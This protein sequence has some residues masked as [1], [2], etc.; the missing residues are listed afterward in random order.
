VGKFPRHIT[1]GNGDG[2]FVEA[3]DGGRDQALLA[4]LAAGRLADLLTLGDDN[5]IGGGCIHGSS[6]QAAYRKPSRWVPG[7][8]TRARKSGEGPD[9]R[10]DPPKASIC[11]PSRPRSWNPFN[12]HAPLASPI[13]G[14]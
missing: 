10:E 9:Y 7:L 13:M 3:V 2:G 6:Y 12:S 14:P 1:L 11:F 8:A 5:G 4:E